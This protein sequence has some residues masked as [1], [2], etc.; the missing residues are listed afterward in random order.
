[1]PRRPRSVPELAAAPFRGS[2][3]VAAG[4]LTK[5]DLRGPA[6]Q[7]VFPDVHLAAG[8]ELTHAVRLTAALVLFPRAVVAGRSAARVWGIDVD[9]PAGVPGDVE[10]LLPLVI[11]RSG[12]RRP[13]R[14][15]RVPGIRVG[16]G[17]VLVRDLVALPGHPGRLV[18][19]PVAGALSLAAELPHVEAVVLLDQYCRP[20]AV[21]R[22]LTDLEELRARAATLTGRGCRLVRAAV[23]DADGKAESPQETRLRLLVHR[24]SLPRPVAQW[25]VLDHRGKEV[26]RVD[27]AWP[28]LRL[29]LEYDGEGHLTRLGPDRRRMN[30]LQ[31]AGWRVLF[32]T[33]ADLYDPVRLLARIAEALAERRRTVA[34]LVEC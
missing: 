30:D 18:L 9:G 17:A 20:T 16:R 11:E 28:D 8:V 22:R 3:A 33:A 1:M 2:A 31:A 15:Q 26:A 24:G 19:R 6:W 5:A 14:Q 13:A 7:R 23:A 29:A 10:I 4:L 21:A 12:R 27:L 34:A 25:R 32:V